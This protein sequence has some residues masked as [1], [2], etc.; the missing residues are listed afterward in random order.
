MDGFQ[1]CQCQNLVLTVL[2]VPYS[3]DSGWAWCLRAND[4]YLVITCQEVCSLVTH[5][6]DLCAGLNTEV[7]AERKLG[8]RA[9]I[10]IELVTQDRKLKASR[11]GST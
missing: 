5:C 6:E 10:F 9:I 8:G 2:S 11:E 7:K 3:L 1:D 4:A